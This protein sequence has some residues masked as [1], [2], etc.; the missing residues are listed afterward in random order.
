MAGGTSPEVINLRTFVLLAPFNPNIQTE[1]IRYPSICN[2]Q[3][4][5]LPLLK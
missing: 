5:V 1:A 4:L 2:F 3:S